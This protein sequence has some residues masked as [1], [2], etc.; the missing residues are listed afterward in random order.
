MT[1]LLLPPHLR[2]AVHKQAAA[3]RQSVNAIVSDDF[4]T[5]ADVKAQLDQLAAYV[6]ERRE[7][8]P[9][10]HLPKPSGWRIS[11]LMLTIPDTTEGGVLMVEGDRDARA[12]ASPQGVILAM[13]P[14]AYSDPVRF[15]VNGV[16]TPWHAVGDRIQ[17]VKYDAQPF[18]LPNGQRLG[19]L[20]DTQPVSL[21]DSGWEVVA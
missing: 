9:N 16:L 4:A 5:P 18:Q 2:A 3:K 7:V 1:D 10:Y 20:T 13:G 11:V 15:S 19:V 17:F 12:V 21:L 6:R 8:Q 14:N